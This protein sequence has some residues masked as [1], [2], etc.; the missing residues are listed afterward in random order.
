MA[1]RCVVFDLDDTLFLERDY[2]RSGFAAVAAWAHSELGVPGLLE[3]AW[4]AFERGTRH[5]VF[6]EVLLDAGVEPTEARIAAL[7]SLYRRHVPSLDLLPDARA[8]LETL[9]GRVTL[10][11]ISDGPIESQQAKVGALGLTRWLDPIVLTA[12]LGLGMQKP[13]HRAYELV[14]ARAGCLPQECAYVGDN[15]A[16]DF[17]APAS[18]GW[19]TVRVRRLLGLHARLTSGHDVAAEIPDLSTLPAVLSLDRPAVRGSP[20]S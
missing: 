4:A 8:C 5:T 11:A 1:I 3:A 6:N 2:V 12:E 10:A 15:P 18:L 13:H 17:E 14:Q 20:L 7:V 16:K 9:S 19:R